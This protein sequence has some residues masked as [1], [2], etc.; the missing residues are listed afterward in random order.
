MKGILYP[1]L[2][3][4]AISPAVNAGIITTYFPAEPDVT[5]P[6]NES[7]DVETSATLSTTALAETDYQGTTS[8]GNLTLTGVRWYLNSD[9]DKSVQIFGG[10]KNAD[11]PTPFS[12]MPEEIYDYIVPEDLTLTFE[13]TQ[14]SAIRIY[15]TGK[16]ELLSDANSTVGTVFVQPDTLDNVQPGNEARIF[17]KTF[18]NAVAIKWNFTASATS[19]DVTV[20]AAIKDDGAIT[21]VAD[22]SDLTSDLYTLSNGILGVELGS[23]S[24]TRS[25]AQWKSAIESIV[26]DF[27]VLFELNESD[28]LTA[29]TVTPTTLSSYSEP[30][31][32]EVTSETVTTEDAVLAPGTEY[33]IFAQHITQNTSNSTVYSSVSE[34][35]NFTTEL[36]SNYSLTVQ[37]ET[38]VALDEP[39]SFEFEITSDGEHYGSPRVQVK[40]PFNAL[41]ELNGSLSSFFNGEVIDGD[42]GEGECAVS[43]VNNETFISCDNPMDV[44][45]SMT[46]KATATFYTAGTTNIE[47]RVCETLLDRCDDAEYT[48]FSVTVTADVDEAPDADSGSSSG[49]GAAFWFLLLSLPLTLLR[50][51]L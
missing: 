38:S 24:D 16:A 9:T 22:S 6:A 35:S 2:L 30:L 5:A 45:D 18:S 26:S 27:G 1:V 47:Y 10:M 23:S 37:G 41:D 43:I 21:I 33:T 19:T 42:S 8:S 50:R 29:S 34:A 14:I 13:S 17:V 15:N 31:L 51:S 49:G 7:T 32:S 36:N 40:L 4:A 46:F 39:T 28:V 20:E 11:T 25:L 12:E 48:T 44:G 3:A